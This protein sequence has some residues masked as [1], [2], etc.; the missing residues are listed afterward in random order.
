MPPTLG[1]NP[2]A[3][4]DSERNE[5]RDR[6]YRLVKNCGSAASLMPMAQWIEYVTAAPETVA[7]LVPAFTTAAVCLGQRH[8]A[9]STCGEGLAVGIR[10][11]KLANKNDRHRLH[12]EF[13]HRVASRQHGPAQ[14]HPILRTIR[15]R[16]TLG[17]RKAGYT[18]HPRT[19]KKVNN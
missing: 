9:P 13:A 5:R 19:G 17:G 14:A 2:F 8:A 12:P 15:R 18:Q 7:S 4:K 16:R 10:R 6:Y 11:R 3:R 1:G